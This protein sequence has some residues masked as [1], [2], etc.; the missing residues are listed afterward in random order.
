MAAIK[1]LLLSLV[2]VWALPAS[3]Q[4][5]RQMLAEQRQR[6]EAAHA[7][8]L[9]TC[10]SRFNVT[11]CEEQARLVRAAAL[12]PVLA[13]EQALSAEERLARSKAQRARVQAKQQ[14]ADSLDGQR[15]Q[16]SLLRGLPSAAS[17]P[18]PALPAMPRIDA[19]AHAR[20]VKAE[21]ARSERS[22]E[23]NRQR[24]IERERQAQVL[25]ESVDTK[26]QQRQFKTKPP[27]PL[28]VPSASDIA[29][30]PVSAASAVPSSSAPR[31]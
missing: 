27:L 26:R 14:E 16:R 17:A 5:E 6:I 31:P 12:K 2:C 22:A 21:I 3:A 23:R 15:M 18:R 8:A 25:R 29:A 9:Q 30:L 13:R 28:P 10:A 20:D 11:A 4:S 1:F 19:Q 24:A 7:Q